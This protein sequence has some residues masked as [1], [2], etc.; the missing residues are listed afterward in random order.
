MISKGSISS[1]LLVKEVHTLSYFA[2]KVLP[3]SN[4]QSDIL[5]KRELNV[6]VCFILI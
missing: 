6:L 4:P 2:V 1:V 5:F 3:R